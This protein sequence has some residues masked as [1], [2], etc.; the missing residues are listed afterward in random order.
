MTDTQMLHSLIAISTSSL[1]GAL[2]IPLSAALPSNLSSTPL[3]MQDLTVWAEERAGL[4]F[5]RRE[6]VRAA[7]KGVE[8][9]L[10][11]SGAR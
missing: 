10:R 9:V 5:S 8:D 4:E 7:A 1:T 6:S 2:P 11:L 3:K